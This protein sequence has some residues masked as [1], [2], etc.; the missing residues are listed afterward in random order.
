[1]KVES[2]TYLGFT[3]FFAAIGLLYWFTSY[4]DAGSVL[5][6]GAALLGLLLGG[7][8]YHLSRR[9]P[10]RTQDDPHA[11]LADGAGTVGEFPAPTVW[12]F[13]FGFGATVL[14]TGTV[15][16]VYVVVGGL[17]VAGLGLVGM[18]RQSRGVPPLQAD[19]EE[20]AEGAEG[21]TGSS[22]ST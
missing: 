10:A 16:G 14:A 18:V 6:A 19:V 17:L 15:F 1:V 11:T 4:E 8:L 22:A 12:P 2:R 9:I 7:F 5:L 3:A 13:V 20:E 21:A